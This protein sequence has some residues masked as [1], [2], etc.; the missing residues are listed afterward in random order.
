M[1]CYKGR[2][3]LFFLEY[4]VKEQFV[5]TNKELKQ[6][7]KRT[8]KK[9]YLLLLMLIV[10]AVLFGNEFGANKGVF[11][12][13]DIVDPG[14]T[15]V[16]EAEL[17][18]LLPVGFVSHNNVAPEVIKDILGDD[19]S[20]G[21]ELAQESEEEFESSGTTVLGHTEGVTAYLIN[22]VSSGTLAL[23]IYESFDE[24]TGSKEAAKAAFI[25]L[26][27]ILYILFGVFLPE[28]YAVIMRRMFMEA[29]V[30]EN[31]PLSHAAHLWK[32]RRAMGAIKT[33]VLKDFFHIL[34]TLT[35]A[36]Y[37][38]KRYSYFLVPYIVAENPD[39]K[40]LE[41]IT[42]S[43]KMMDGH[44]MEAFKFELS[45]FH[46]LIL[47]VVTLG[48]S[49]VFWYLPYK[50]AATAE[51]YFCV[52]QLAK[53]AD[54]EGAEM[55]DDPV[56]FTK[57][58]PELLEEVYGDVA[59]E[60]A[61]LKENRIQ[62]T[63]ARKFFAEKLAIWVGSSENKKTYQRQENREYRMQEDWAAM[64]GEAYPGRL[65]PRNSE[66]NR[67]IGHQ[68][69]FLRCY[70]IWN[71]IVMFL[72][73]AFI[74]WLWEVFVFLIQTGEF[75]NRGTLHGPWVPI[76]GVGGA[77]IIVVLSSLRKRPL[78]EFFAI[79]VL[80][81]C[82]EYF[83]SWAL[84]AI[85]GMRWW[86][87]SGYFLNL[88]GRICLEGLVAFGVLGLM[89]IYM[90]APALDI[91]LMKIPPRIMAIGASI[92]IAIFACDVGYSAINPNTGAGITDMG[93]TLIT[94]N[95]RRHDGTL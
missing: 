87:Y 45:F 84:E 56:L 49:N 77:M 46:W 74:G 91:L 19:L 57:A 27:L 24:I 50:V 23:M 41:A 15:T 44:K 29:R 65:D 12:L 4:R 58:D 40:P 71:L 33:I 62:L 21:A 78:V 69:N 88:D 9:H 86:D 26:G 75:Y 93:N 14:R 55:L 25:I 76:Y 60:R 10:I 43:R 47:G 64:H 52:R 72:L 30:Y 82:I 32:V 38:I 73:F 51:Y 11:Y 89:A 59:R 70:T 92:L 83:T 34:W 63:G 20:S 6:S 80:C 16:K 68:I 81:G 13:S 42:L 37:F 79:V 90:L 48:L 3:C 53:E 61:W 5:L 94:A 28:V 36:G 8:V 95:T 67:K 7:G 39:I 31:V 22:T 85:Y 66:D 35:I 1:I 17:E 54:V 18:N 2:P